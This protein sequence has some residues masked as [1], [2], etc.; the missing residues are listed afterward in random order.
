MAVVRVPLGAMT[1]PAMGVGWVFDT[2]HELFP[3]EWN[4]D[5]VSLSAGANSTKQMLVRVIAVLMSKCCKGFGGYQKE[6][7]VLLGRAKKKWGWAS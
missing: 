4:L 5:V 3:I 1:S 2:S 6:V 7:T